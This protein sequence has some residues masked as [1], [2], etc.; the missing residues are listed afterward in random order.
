VQAL[1]DLPQRR[2]EV[3][4]VFLNSAQNVC[5][6][7]LVQ[8][9]QVPRFSTGAKREH[10]G[11]EVPTAA[12]IQ[13][14]RENAMRNKSPEGIV[15]PKSRQGTDCTFSLFCECTGWPNRAR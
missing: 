3:A 10:T 5:G 14:H 4:A 12:I 1:S 11:C 7:T 13:R 2:P 8:D 6:F 9:K 15:S